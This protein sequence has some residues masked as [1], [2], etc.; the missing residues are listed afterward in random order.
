MS[1]LCRWRLARWATRRSSSTS[2]M[3]VATSVSYPIC[4]FFFCDCI[5]G[6]SWLLRNRIDVTA[7]TRL[8]SRDA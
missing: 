7:L 8:T 6:K 3:Q 5:I 1:W 2:L 4:E